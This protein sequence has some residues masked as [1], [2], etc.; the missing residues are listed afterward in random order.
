M[1]NVLKRIISI[2][3]VT[4]F[5]IPLL[6]LVFFKWLMKE[7]FN[8]NLTFVIPKFQF[9]GKQIVGDKPSLRKVINSSNTNDVEQ[10][11]CEADLAE[12]EAEYE[13]Y[14]EDEENAENESGLESTEL[15]EE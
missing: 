3:I 11:E 2:L 12:D 13:E 4:T 5:I 8:L 10:A 9:W 7:V 14:V 6:V 15:E 1:K